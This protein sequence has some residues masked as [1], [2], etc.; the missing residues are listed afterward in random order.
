MPDSTT[1]AYLLAENRLLREALGRVLG[2]K[3]DIRVVGAGAL[4]A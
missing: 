1:Q 2:K 4:G 3:V